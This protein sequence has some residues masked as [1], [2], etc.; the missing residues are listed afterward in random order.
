MSFEDM[1][2]LA[3]L[4]TQI[5][6]DQ[7]KRGVINYDMG[8]LDRSPDGLSI[9]KPISDQIR[10]LRDDIFTTSGALSPKAVG[11]SV[12]LMQAQASRVNILNGA[13]G[14]AEATELAAR[15]QVYFSSQGM[16]V[17]GIGSADKSYDTTTV[18]LHNADLYTLRY[19]LD[20]VGANSNQQVVFRFD[21]AAGSDVDIMLG[22]DWAINNP[23][24]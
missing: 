6:V 1:L 19:I 8:I 11:D 10:V 22:N 5:D 24:P 20:L 18:V 12:T 15:S 9:L 13:Y 17:V 14:I 4:A 7:I 16:N 3:S 21:P 23:M 2:K